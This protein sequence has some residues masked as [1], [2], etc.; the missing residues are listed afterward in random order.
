MS[1][2]LSDR[3]FGVAAFASLPARSPLCVP[4]PLDGCSRLCRKK[5]D[6]R[7]PCVTLSDGS[8]TNKKN[9]HREAFLLLKWRTFGSI[10]TVLPEISV[11]LPAQ[12]TAA[13]HAC[14]TQGPMPA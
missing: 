3:D 9:L 12:R 13:D 8:P 14:P 1:F 5:V 7:T 2:C 6:F 11:A 4:L 10:P